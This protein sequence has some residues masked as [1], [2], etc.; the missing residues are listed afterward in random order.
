MSQFAGA[1]ELSYSG[2]D[3]FFGAFVAAE[4]PFAFKNC[5]RQRQ[6][7]LRVHCHK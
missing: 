7:M 2:L 4:K 5:C 3:T 1:I 6:L